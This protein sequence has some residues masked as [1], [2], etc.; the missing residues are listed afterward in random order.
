MH[1]TDLWVIDVN[2]V[3]VLTTDFSRIK[4]EEFQ[5][6]KNEITGF[7]YYRVECICRFTILGTSIK[8]ELWWKGQLLN[9]IV[10]E[11]IDKPKEHMLP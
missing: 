7:I 2:Q 9:G 10:V 6:C 8:C 4:I 11:N 5:R 3:G 1:R